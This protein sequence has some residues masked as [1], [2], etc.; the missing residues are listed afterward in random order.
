MVEGR[1][2]KQLQYPLRDKHANLYLWSGLLFLLKFIY[3]FY[4][5]ESI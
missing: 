5:I 2:Q 1:V 3:R 4:Q